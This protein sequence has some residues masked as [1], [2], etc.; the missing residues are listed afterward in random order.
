[1]NT[2]IYFENLA[3]TITEKELMDLFSAYGNVATVRIAV[4]PTNQRPS[5]S[6]FVAMITPEGA[7]TAIQSL[8]GKALS[9]GTLT[10]SETSPGREPVGSTNERIPHR[11]VSHLY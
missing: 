1:M 10:L 4:D 3:A 9:S 5:G 11:K 8:N 6:G 7:R 2:R